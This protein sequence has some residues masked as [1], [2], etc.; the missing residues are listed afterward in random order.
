[1]SDGLSL[2]AASFSSKICNSPV[3]KTLVNKCFNVLFTWHTPSRRLPYFQF[4]ISLL[5]TKFLSLL[6]MSQFQV[7]QFFQFLKKR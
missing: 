1:M 3:I 4:V 5:G 7:V 2:R 6:V